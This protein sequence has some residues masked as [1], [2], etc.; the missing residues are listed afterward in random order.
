MNAIRTPGEKSDRHADPADS[1]RRRANKQRGHGTVA[2]D[3][4]PIFSVVSRD[5]GA[6]RYV[7][8]VQATQETCRAIV[9]TYV[10]PTRA[11]FYTDEWSGYR[12]VHLVHSTGCHS[13]REWARDNDGDGRREVHCN[14][15]EGWE[16]A[17][18]TF[19][20]AFRGRHKAYLACYV[21]MFE[22]IAKAKR[23]TPDLVRRM[24]DGKLICT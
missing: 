23:I 16:T 10:P 8:C 5:T 6:I 7:V 22:A 11:V 20:R 17:L 2:N 14:P 12:D 1:P 3:R 18:R 15:Y 19:L 21:A 13:T 24:C 9:T 4:P